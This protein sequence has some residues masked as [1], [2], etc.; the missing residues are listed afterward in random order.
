MAEKLL[1]VTT[2]AAWA[3]AGQDGAVP[4]PPEGFIHLCTEA[5]RGFVLE[6]HFAGRGALLVLHVD[7]AGLD[8]IWEESEPGMTSFPHLYEALPLSSV[9]QIEPA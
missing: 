5:Q 1:H 4:C 2:E 6:R 7:P 9:L 3:E 8:I